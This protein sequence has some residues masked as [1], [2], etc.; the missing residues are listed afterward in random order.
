MS[1]PLGLV[2]LVGLLLSAC[3]AQEGRLFRSSTVLMNTVVSITVAAPSEAQAQEAIQAA[4]QEIRKAEKLLSFWDEE[5]EIS[6][7]NRSAGRRPVKVS[8]ETFRLVETA[9]R[10]CLQSDGGFDPTIGPLMRLWDF[11]RGVRP[12]QE[13]LKKA[14]PLVDCRQVVL[15]SQ[16]RTVWLKHRGM[17]ID[18]GGIAK[19]YA[20]DLAV[21]ALRA[22]G[23]KAALVA[24]AGDIRAFG[25][26]PD[27]SP[28]RI[29]IKAPRR[30]G[31][32]GVLQIQEGAVST[33]GDYERFFIQEG[34]R[35]HHL[36][37]PWTG[38]PARGLQ[39]LTVLAPQGVLSDALATGLFVL[40]PERALRKLK[41]LG[42]EAVLVLQDGK[43][44]I[45]EGL[46]DKVRLYEDNLS[47]M[48]KDHY[49][50]GKPLEALLLGKVQAH[51]PGQ[52]GLGAVPDTLAGGRRGKGA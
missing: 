37:K 16:A 3:R 23:I 50:G 24:V 15:D 7:I 12:S 5:S 14:L 18:T 6:A 31:L 28:W 52:V 2:L 48:Q 44:Y 42:L 34:V 11:K 25:R 19:G 32:L 41:E 17:S 36:L 47:H 51:R 45:T 8:E 29:G 39:Q 4:F 35:Y 43:I 26:K 46:R 49:L 33:S 21:K 9:I 20:A 27:G 30:E 10:L 13:A 22:W 38:L 40:G 1:R